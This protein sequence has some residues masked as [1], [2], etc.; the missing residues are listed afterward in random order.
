MSIL[1][2]GVDEYVVTEGRQEVGLLTRS[3]DLDHVVT[4]R[5]HFL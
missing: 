3:V 4:L 2:E 5:Y 1:V